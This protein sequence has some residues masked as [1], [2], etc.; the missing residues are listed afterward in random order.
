MVAIGWSILTGPSS[1]DIR[2]DTGDLRHRVLGIPIYYERMPE[3]QRTNLLSLAQRSATLSSEWCSLAPQ[4]TSNSPKRMCRD[5]YYR[6]A[7]WVDEDPAM[8]AMIAEDVT[9]YIRRT[10]AREGGPETWSLLSCAQIGPSGEMTIPPNWREDEH[11]QQY[12]SWKG[13]TP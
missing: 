11:V 9:Q 3:P 4:Q 1:V 2:L 7:A 5:F 12:F 8:A 10:H 6:V 13:R